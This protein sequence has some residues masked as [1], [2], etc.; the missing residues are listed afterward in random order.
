M[1]AG[2]PLNLRQVNRQLGRVSNVVVGLVVGLKGILTLAATL[3]IG[4]PAHHRAGE[5]QR[6]KVGL[7][8]RAGFLKKIAHVEGDSRLRHAE[9][10]GD[11]GGA[12]TAGQRTCD[13]RFSWR[14][15]EELH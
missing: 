11:I 1:L 6:D 7:A 4:Y 3:L 13:F 12:G 8:V 14:Q 2:Q 5:D 15:A 9:L 10:G